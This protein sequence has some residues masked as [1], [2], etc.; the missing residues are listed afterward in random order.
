MEME[1]EP[2]KETSRI[3]VS[4]IYCVLAAIASIILSCFVTLF[5]IEPLSMI[6]TAGAAFFFGAGFVLGL[7]SLAVIFIRRKRTKGFLWAIL[8][9]LLSVVPMYFLVGIWLGAGARAELGKAHVGTYNLHILGKELVKYA[10]KHDG[11]LP[12]A[13]HWCEELL[14]NNLKLSEAN[15]RHPQSRIVGLKGECHFAFNRNLSEMRLADIPGDV[16]LVF[17]ADG[18]WNLNGTEELLKTRY[19]EQG[20]ITIFIAN[21]KMLDYWFYK[22]AIR[23]FDKRRGM[24]YEKPRWKP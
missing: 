8:S 5:R 16:V 19:R 17:E 4:S 18:S 2:V 14:K 10:E 13:N 1:R 9:I 21:G 12:V 15:F 23:K 24:Y 3:A 7:L 6:F 22:S 11:Y 20:F